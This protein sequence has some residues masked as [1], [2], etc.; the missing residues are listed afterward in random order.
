MVEYKLFDLSLGKSRSISITEIPISITFGLFDDFEIMDPDVFEEDLI[1]DTV[2]VVLGM[3]NKTLSILKPGGKPIS[4][5]ML[6]TM[7]DK[8]RERYVN[9]YERIEEFREQLSD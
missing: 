6:N 8:A 3:N 1:E 7:R 5:T 2:T 4:D 9:V